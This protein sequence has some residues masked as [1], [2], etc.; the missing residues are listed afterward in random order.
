MINGVDVSVCLYM[1]FCGEVNFPKILLDNF[2]EHYCTLQL[3]HFHP[4]LDAGHY[5]QA[6]AIK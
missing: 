3:E 4:F 5:A 1:F 2:V 6:E